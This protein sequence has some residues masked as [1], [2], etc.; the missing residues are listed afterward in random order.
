MKVPDEITHARD[1]ALLKAR[2]IVCPEAVPAEDRREEPLT[3]PAQRTDC[4]A[5][6][7]SEAPFKVV[8]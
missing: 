2:A 1:V 5:L 4:H 3:R 8:A 6:S 7:R